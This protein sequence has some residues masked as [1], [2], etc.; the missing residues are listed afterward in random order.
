MIIWASYSPYVL[1]CEF[2]CSILAQKCKLVQWWHE[3][4]MTMRGF[5]FKSYYLL[6]LSRFVR[7]AVCD[8]ARKNHFCLAS[9]HMSP[10]GAVMWRMLTY[11]PTRR[12]LLVGCGLQMFQ[13]VS[14]INTVMWVTLCT[15]WCEAGYF[16]YYPG[17]TPVTGAKQKWSGVFQLLHGAREWSCVDRVPLHTVVV[18][19][20]PTGF[21]EKI[22]V[23]YSVTKNNC[24]YFPFKY[25]I[26][27]T[28][29]CTW[30]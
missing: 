22:K 3:Q 30:I 11:P 9:A 14:G 23:M 21:L 16:Q 25:Y 6:F 24:I 13:Q 26:F 17:N 5:M 10:D 27:R 29:E 18:V 19:A 1:S 15:S 4:M 12:A 8:F 2:F 7:V 20:P 28:M